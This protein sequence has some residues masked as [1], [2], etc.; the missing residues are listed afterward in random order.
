MAFIIIFYLIKAFV[1]FVLWFYH[2]ITCKMIECKY[3]KHAR[4]IQKQLRSQLFFSELHKIYI[5]AFMEIAISIILTI[6][7]GVI[8]PSGEFLGY[9]LVCFSLLVIFV[10]IP[11]SYFMLFCHK[12]SVLSEDK[13]FDKTYG[14]LIKGIR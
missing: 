4:R 3:A 8:S 5:E 10:Q 12:K 1:Y 2:Y 13:K 6:K 9:T 11:F 14:T 7:I